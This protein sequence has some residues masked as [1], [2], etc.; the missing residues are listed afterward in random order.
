MEERL[1]FSFREVD[2]ESLADA[3]AVENGGDRKSNVFNL[4]IGFYQGNG[5]R[6]DFTGIIFDGFNKIR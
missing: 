5:Q 1:L 4:I 3:V 6:Q 2:G